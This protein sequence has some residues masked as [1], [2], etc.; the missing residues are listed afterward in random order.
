MDFVS[1]KEKIHHFA[2]NVDLS[3][4]ETPDPASVPGS[5]PPLFIINAQFPL[6]YNM[7]AGGNEDGPGFSMVFY[8]APSKRLIDAAKTPD[9]AHNAVKLLLRYFERCH[10]D[11]NVKGLFKIICQ[12]NDEKAATESGVP[13]FALR[14]NAKPVI[15]KKTGTMY[16]GTNY[17]EYDVNVFDFGLIARKGFNE[18][19]GIF[20]DLDMNVGF[21]IQAGPDDEQ[22]ENILG[23]TR[24][25]N[26]NH[27]NLKP[28]PGHN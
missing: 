17:V 2:E 28:M 22:P 13:S 15:I 25:M 23:C 26:P 12:L 20:K 5:L 14:Y 10:D 1:C 6:N 18:Y 21:V 4:L 8:F 24:I 11:I 27:A 19:M 7:W 3:N 16:K 9:T